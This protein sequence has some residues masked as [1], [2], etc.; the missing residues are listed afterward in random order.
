MWNAP[1]CWGLYFSFFLDPYSGMFASSRNSTHNL[2]QQIQEW[3][4]APLHPKELDGILEMPT[5]SQSLPMHPVTIPNN[6]KNT[7]KVFTCL[8]FCFYIKR[9]WSLPC[10]DSTANEVPGLYAQDWKVQIPSQFCFLSIIPFTPNSPYFSFSPEI[11]WGFFPLFFMLI[12]EWKLGITFPFST[13]V[14]TEGFNSF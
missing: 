10:S 8:V 12:T 4:A 13:Q 11:L 9:H 6:Q 2:L 7:Q 14:K 5:P 3:A 1:R